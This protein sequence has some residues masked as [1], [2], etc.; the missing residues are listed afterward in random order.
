MTSEVLLKIEDLDKSFGI[1]HANDHISLNLNKG[2][3]RCLAGENGSGKSTLTSIISGLQPYDSGTMTL[4]GKEYRPKS[5]LDAN[6][7]NV[8]MVVQELGVITAL[9][10]AMNIFLGKTDQ[11]KKAGLVNTRAMVSAAEDIFEKWGIPKVPLNIPCLYLTMEQRKMV[12]LARALNSDPKL[13]ILDEIT[14]ALSHDTRSVIYK[15]K[16][17]FKQEERSM[18]II[19]H[20][21]EE[22]V[23]ISDSITILRDGQMVETVQSAEITV[24]GLKQKMVG[25]KI[26]GAY[27]RTDNEADYED[28]V[29]LDVKG[30][31]LGNGQLDNVSFQ[32]H[33]GEILGICGLSDAGIH[34]L[35]SAL[36]GISDSTRTGTVTDKKT[37]KQ[38]KSPRD[39]IACG[40]AYLSKN[41][42][43]EGLMMEAS[44]RN[45]MYLPSMAE[46]TGKAQ[47]VNP[48]KV[49]EL[50]QNAF[51]DFN[52]KATGIKQPIGR[53]SGGNKQKINLGRWLT[54]DLNY[55]ILDCPTRGVD[56]GVKAYIYEV[57]RKRKA[58]GL[59]IILIT[60]ELTE[61]IGMADR[62][63][64]L[65]NG[66][67]AGEVSRGVD[68]TESSIIE[69]MI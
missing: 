40:G 24:D 41:R 5:P 3:I 45:N 65:R 53:L 25:R 60:D 32:L 52:V 31:S 69:V 64:V 47:F 36:Y 67:V 49:D 58:N 23:E 33:K 9:T 14:Q 35:G 8:A 55:V 54:K 68:F 26:E 20:D 38:L 16:D 42:D 44:I 66:K 63:L 50:A 34:P 1:T 15:L 4:G 59:G 46:L 29:L 61:A 12:E 27:F 6:E 30:L 11:F 10:G 28:E 62:I 21:L 22:T 57:M 56:V 37:G 43:E 48:K 51:D 19:S 18:I 13:L 17:R 39:M 2:E 7:R